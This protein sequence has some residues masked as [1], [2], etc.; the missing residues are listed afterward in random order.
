[1]NSNLNGAAQEPNEFKLEW[2]SAGTFVEDSDA[3]LFRFVLQRTEPLRREPTVLDIRLLCRNV[4]P[5]NVTYDVMFLVRDLTLG[6]F[7]YAI[8]KYIR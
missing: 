3:L 1:M 7:K 2:C 4:E 6:V 8:N 5:D